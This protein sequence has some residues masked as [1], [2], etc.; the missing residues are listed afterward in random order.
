MYQHTTIDVSSY[1]NKCHHITSDDQQQG[2][3]HAN[4]DVIAMFTLTYHHATN[5][6]IVLKYDLTNASLER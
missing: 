5:D 6:F 1:H 2:H 3:R 4:R